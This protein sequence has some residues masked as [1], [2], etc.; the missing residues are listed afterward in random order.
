[1]KVRPSDRAIG[2]GLL[3][4]DPKTRLAIPAEGVEVPGRPSYWLRR[5]ADG[6][7][8]EVLEHEDRPP[9]TAK[10]KAKPDTE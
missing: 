10:R 9:A 7:A 8:V 3:L 4:V 5:I 6:D 1:M 2:A